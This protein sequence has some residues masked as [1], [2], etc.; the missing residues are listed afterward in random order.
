MFTASTEA[1]FP[2][3]SCTRLDLD[4]FQR[5]RARR[6]PASQAC[7]SAPW[8]GLLDRDKSP[9]PDHTRPIEAVARRGKKLRGRDR[10]K[11]YREGLGHMAC[12]TRNCMYQDSRIDLHSP[13]FGLLV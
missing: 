13:P 5:R 1:P 4:A 6:N 12:A 10:L 8:I 2:P 11:G 3:A 7:A 9:A